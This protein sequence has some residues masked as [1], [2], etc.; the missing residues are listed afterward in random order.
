M[1]REGTFDQ[2]LVARTVEELS[3]L[4]GLA[5]FDYEAQELR[6][7]KQI[8]EQIQARLSQ[9]GA[10]Q[11]FRFQPVSEK[12]QA[13]YE[14]DFLKKIN[15]FEGGVVVGGEMAFDNRQVIPTNLLKVDLGLKRV[16]E[17]SRYQS[18]LAV[19]V[20][21]CEETRALGSWD[22]SVATY[23][24]YDKQLD[25]GLESYLTGP[26]VLLGIHRPA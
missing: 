1:P 7:S 10:E 2:A 22:S 12:P 14:L 21:F 3:T 18:S 4:L 25:W 26:L 19:L 9:W 23:E 13:N 24:E 5:I 17:A 15:F 8:Q 6:S 11:N 16:R 20:T